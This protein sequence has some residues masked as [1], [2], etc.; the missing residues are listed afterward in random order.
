MK[1]RITIL[2]LVI[3]T[4]GAFSCLSISQA[5]AKESMT[6]GFSMSLTGKYAPGAAGQMQ[7]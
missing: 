7:A 5:S 1:K 3:V 2:M 6:V 4:I